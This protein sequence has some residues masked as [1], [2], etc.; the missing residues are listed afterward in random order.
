[1]P[2]INVVTPGAAGVV[3]L[4]DEPPLGGEQSAVGL[5]TSDGSEWRR[6]GNGMPLGAGG[7]TGAFVGLPGRLVVFTWT[8]TGNAAWIG[9]PGG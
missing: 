5:W 9:T 3:A 6:I 7:L 2:S 4:V 1:M 8:G